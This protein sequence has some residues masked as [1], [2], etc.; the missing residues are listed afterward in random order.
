MRTED[1]LGQIAEATSYV[2]EKADE[3]SRAAKAGEDRSAEQNELIEK[4]SGQVMS[5]QESLKKNQPYP[6]NAPI[7]SA[8]DTRTMFNGR[9]TAP[10]QR[11]IST[12]PT[13]P[14][15]RGTPEVENMVRLQDLHDAVTFRYWAYHAKMDSTMAI[16]QLSKHPDTAMWAR[17]LKKH[18]YIQDV[19]TFLNPKSGQLAEVAMT[20]ANEVLSPANTSAGM[21]NLTFT[22][23]SGQLID[24][25]YVDLVFGNNVTRI[26]LTRSSM[27]FPKLT[28][29]TQGVWGGIANQPTTDNVEQPTQGGTT[30]LP[31]AITYLPHDSYFQRPT[32]GSLQ[33]DA[34]HIMSFL[35]FNDDMLED[36]IIPWLPFCRNEL[37]KNIARAFDDAICNGHASGASITQDGFTD[38]HAT[39]AWNGIRYDIGAQVNG[40]I[41]ATV[42]T[43]TSGNMVNGA[44]A[45]LGITLIETAILQLGKYALRTDQLVMA[46]RPRDYIRIM[47]LAEFKTYD[48]SGP[49]FN[50]HTGAVGQIYGI[51]IVPTDVIRIANEYGALNAGPGLDGTDNKSTALIW[52]RDMYLLGMFDTVQMESTRWAPRFMTILQA[53]VRADMQSVVGQSSDNS[54]GWPAVGIVNL[55]Q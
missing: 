19:S 10:Y 9:L 36:S 53:D 38:N 47:Q 48:K 34:E 29:I 12:S 25:V 39:R 1:V 14:M 15:V 45:A 28:G 37:S 6:A 23:V 11:M 54:S 20:R 51:D 40:W 22:L 21:N 16:D 5:L 49:S 30:Q 35:L 17:E 8:E 44:G 41:H 32:I 43:Y 33:F 3:A 24:Q 4:L 2:R 42:P 27:K 18:G 26:P 46:V 50:L 31:S 55:L 13:H 52:R 7:M